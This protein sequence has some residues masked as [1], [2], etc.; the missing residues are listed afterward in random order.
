M[1]ISSTKLTF[2]AEKNLFLAAG[3]GL[4]FT[5]FFKRRGQL[6]TLTVLLLS[7]VWC[8]LRE[9]TG[10]MKPPISLEGIVDHWVDRRG[11]SEEKTNRG[12]AIMA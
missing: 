8:V 3:A 10:W 4:V 9:A 5:F 11:G 12:N 1:A 7:F 6:E 2:S